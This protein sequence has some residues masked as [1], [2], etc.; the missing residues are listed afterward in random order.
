MHKASHGDI[1][2]A[3]EKTVDVNLHKTFKPGGI[4]VVSFKCVKEIT[5]A[6]EDALQAALLNYHD[7]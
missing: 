1:K 4:E 3:G 2:L 7:E 6:K 5:M